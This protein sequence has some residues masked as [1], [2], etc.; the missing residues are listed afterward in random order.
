MFITEKTWKP[1]LGLRPFIINGQPQIYSYLRKNGFRTFNQYWPVNIEDIPEYQLHNA[2]IS[3]IKYLKSLPSATI[4]SIYNNML[5]DLLHNQARF[6]EFA[7]EQHA[8]IEN[9]FQ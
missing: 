5:P 9:L 2:I 7:Q 4:L 8:I 3:I 1:I 6:Q